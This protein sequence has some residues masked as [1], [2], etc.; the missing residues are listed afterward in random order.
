MANLKNKKFQNIKKIKVEEKKQEHFGS[1]QDSYRASTGYRGGV[2]NTVS[3]FQGILNDAR[4][5]VE[6]QPQEMTQAGEKI[7]LESVQWLEGNENG[8]EWGVQSRPNEVVKIQ[9]KKQEIEFSR[10]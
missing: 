2:D 5:D 1:E 10:D 4:M 9:D 8:N 6:P 3:M 7:D